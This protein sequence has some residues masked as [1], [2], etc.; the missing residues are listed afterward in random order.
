MPG[1]QHDPGGAAE[2]ADGKVNLCAE[3]AAGAA[4]GLIASPFFAPAACW[5]ARTMVLSMMRYSKSGSSAMAAKMR[6]QTPLALHRQKRRNAL[7]Q[8]PKASGRSR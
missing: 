2:S 4:D 8:L 7:F 5:W 6:C 3:A 1:C